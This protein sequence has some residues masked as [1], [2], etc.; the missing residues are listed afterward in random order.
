MQE[1]KIA[2][3][4]LIKN[5]TSKNKI[6]VLHC[7]TEYPANIKKLN[8][9]SIKYLKDK[10]KCRVGFSD[11]SKGFEASLLSLALGASILRNTLH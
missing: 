5:G 8:L 10:L 7:C 4:L 9:N 3:N 1:I 6:S 11:H 2:M